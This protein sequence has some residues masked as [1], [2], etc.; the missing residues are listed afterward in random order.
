MKKSKKN[1]LI[2]LLVVIL[3]TLAIGYAAFNQ[4]LNISG[5]ASA[6]GTFN[7]HFNGGTV[8]AGTGTATGTTDT[9]TV[10]ATLPAPGTGTTI[11]AHIVN[12]GTV[13]AKLTGYTVEGTGFALVGG[14]TNQYTDGVIIV[15][16][17]DIDTDGS[18]TLDAVTGACNVTFDVEWDSNNTTVSTPHNATF[19]IKLTYEQDVTTF[20]P[21]V[22]HTNP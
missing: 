16:V 9:L 20:T 13:K 11:T 1:Y 19:T 22:N 2:I 21:G 6:N 3:L 7:V 18:E 4:L 14:T 10:T 12:E 15:T 17:P 5:T 8:V